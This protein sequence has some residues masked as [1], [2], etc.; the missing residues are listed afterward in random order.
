[1]EMYRAM[2]DRLK[3]KNKPAHFRRLRASYWE[4]NDGV[5]GAMT[6]SKGEMGPARW[7][8]KNGYKINKMRF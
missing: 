4:D 8:Q 6:T 3:K 2:H 7:K 1:M 5:M